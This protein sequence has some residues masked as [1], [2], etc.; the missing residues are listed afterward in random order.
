MGTHLD[1]RVYETGTARIEK[2]RRYAYVRTRHEQCRHDGKR[3]RR[4]ITRHID[5]A[6]DEFGFSAYVD[7]FTLG[8]GFDGDVGAECRQHLLG[9]VACELV[10][11]DAR[12]ARC[13]QCGQQQRGFYLGGRDRDAR[14]D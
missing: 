12:A 7:G 2:N 14:V 11:H 3:R 4:R 5:V 10:L 9:V 8:Q 1:Q 6:G 13:A